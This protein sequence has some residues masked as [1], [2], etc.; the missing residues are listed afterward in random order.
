MTDIREHVLKIKHISVIFDGFKALTDVDI[1]V[2]EIAFIFLSGKTAPAKQRF[3]TLSVP[4]QNLRRG[5]CIT[6]RWE[7]M[8]SG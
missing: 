6:I 8:P 5:Q 4:G 1:N 7:E 3:L 2:K